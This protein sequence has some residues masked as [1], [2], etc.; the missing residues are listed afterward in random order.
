MN[1][2]HTLTAMILL[3]VALVIIGPMVDMMQTAG[4]DFRA[5]IH[6]THEEK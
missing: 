4:E 6:T 3:A 1:T 2:T 5:G